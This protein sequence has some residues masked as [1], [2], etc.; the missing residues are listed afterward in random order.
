[1]PLPP[2]SAV[3]AVKAG[4]C[5]APSQPSDV[6]LLDDFEDGDAQLFKAFDREGWWYSAGDPT[7]GAKLWPDGKFQPE[8]LPAAEAS[9]ANMFAAHFKASGQKGWGA[10][11]GVG[12]HWE[13][14]GIRCPLNASAFAGIRLRAKGPGTVRV[15]IGIPETEPAEGGG[16]CTSGCYD[17]HGQVLFLSDHWSDYLVRWDRVQQGG[18]GAEARFQ[19]ERIVNLAFSTKAADLPADF[20]VDDIAFV[21]PHEAEVLAAAERAQ[22][23]GTPSGAR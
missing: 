4:P 14:Q 22:P 5:A 19:P 9:K 17:F 10:I 16:A 7:P 11:W 3:P 12:L 20:W 6:A 13:S 23:P 18:W 8:R 1:M 21:A 15:S 2:E